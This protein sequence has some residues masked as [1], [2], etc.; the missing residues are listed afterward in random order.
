M[1]HIL[2]LILQQIDAV[3]LLLFTVFTYI[4]I[5]NM[6]SL[7]PFIEEGLANKKKSKKQIGK[8]G[9]VK[10]E[11][12]SSNDINKDLKEKINNAY[13]MFLNEATSQIES[14]IRNQGNNLSDMDADDIQSSAREIA[15]KK[16]VDFVEKI[17]NDETDAI[18]VKAEVKN[19]SKKGADS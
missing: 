13:E 6:M 16:L 8:E 11:K 17:L 1:M 14:E 19:M 10:N 5:Y 4:F 7:L 18:N 15:T 12:N 3:I 2:F 9:E